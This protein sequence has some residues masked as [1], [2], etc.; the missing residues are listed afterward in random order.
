MGRTTETEWVEILLDCIERLMDLLRK[1][2]AAEEAEKIYQ[3][4]FGE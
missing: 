3:E 1:T 2:K 4:F